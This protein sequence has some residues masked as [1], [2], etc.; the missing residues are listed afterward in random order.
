MVLPLHPH[1]VAGVEE[2]EQ[3]FLAEGACTKQ[4]EKA[5]GEGPDAGAEEAIREKGSESEEE[6]EEGHG[7]ML[8]LSHHGER[9]V[10]LR[11]QHP[12]AR[13]SNHQLTA[14]GA[15]EKQ[16]QRNKGTGQSCR[17]PRSWGTWNVLEDV[18]CVPLMTRGVQHGFSVACPGS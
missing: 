1:V 17:M 15:K 18:A 14:K 12:M 9:Y 4:M 3:V 6:E 10:A 16:G 13:L 2:E 11:V 5:E 7:S 8:E